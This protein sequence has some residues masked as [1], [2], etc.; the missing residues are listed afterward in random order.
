MSTAL[1]AYGIARLG[2]GE[3]LHL[4]DAKG[5]LCNRWGTTNG[6]WKQ[7]RIIT[8][9]VEATCKRCLKIAS[10]PTPATKGSNA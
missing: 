4:A 9:D 7:A 10:Q 3:A 1:D 2:G 5:V 8:G 6:V